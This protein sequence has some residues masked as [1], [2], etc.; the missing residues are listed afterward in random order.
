M[1]EIGII[2]EILGNRARVAIGSMVTDFLPV[3]FNSENSFKNTWNP[4]K[5]AEQCLVLPI[6]GELNSGVILR[7]L[8]TNLSNTPDIDEN[9]EVTKYSDG[10]IISYDVSS[11]T[12]EIKSPK[13]ININCD[14]IN[15]TCKNANVKA[16]NIIA[17]TNAIKITTLTTDI[18]SPNISL[19]GNTNIIGNLNIAGGISTSGSSGGSGEFKINGNLKVSGS[20]SDNKGDLTGHSHHDTDGYISNPR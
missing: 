17:K 13:S 4:L 7:G 19:K 1:I 6:R 16:D 18:I 20:I 15:L 14:N 8:A 2:S 10:T 3:I 11:S 12:L 9:K 5:I